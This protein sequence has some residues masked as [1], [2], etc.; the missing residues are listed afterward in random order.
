MTETE[1]VRPA[2]SRF[3]HFCF[4]IYRVTA[5]PLRSVYSG[6]I[7][8]GWLAARI[9]W[10]LLSFVRLAR[11]RYMLFALSPRCFYATQKETCLSISL[12]L[13]LSPSELLTPPRT[14]C[15]RE[16]SRRR[17]FKRIKGIHYEG[18]LDYFE[19]HVFLSSRVAAV[20]RSQLPRNV[21]AVAKLQ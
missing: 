7:L 15:R 21:F 13:F 10:E 11:R 17:K 1:A 4:F 16:S 2:G 12:Y 6:Y 20:L 3:T 5:S 18:H 14:R 8:W 9:L 19:F